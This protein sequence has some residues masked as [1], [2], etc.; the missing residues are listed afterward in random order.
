MAQDEQTDQLYDFLYRDSSRLIS[1]YAQIFGGHLISFEKTDQSRTSDEKSGEAKIGVA[2][3]GVSGAKKSAAETIESARQI[4]D[5]HDI[6]VTDVLSALTEA[7]KIDRHIVSA[8]PGTLVHAEGTLVFVDRSMLELGLIAMDSLVEE[9]KKKRGHEK[10]RELI[11]NLEAVKDFMAK[12]HLPS[13]FVLRMPNIVIAGTIKES[14]ME[15]PISTYYY[16]HGASGLSGVQLV[17]IKEVPTSSF[18]IPKTNLIGL[19]SQ[20]AKALHDMLFPADSIKVTP[21]VFFR[22][23]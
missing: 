5:P 2:V 1:L 22:K 20:A 7:G 21:L 14:G 10:N 9:E 13:A 18:E 17:G 19:G 12:M 15:E 16:K 11:R 3:A 8:L 6:K 23:L 4:V